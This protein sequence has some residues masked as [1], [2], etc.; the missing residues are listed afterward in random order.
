M[1]IVLFT[2]VRSGCWEE[3][4]VIALSPRTHITHSAHTG[5]EQQPVVRV[6]GVRPAHT[7]ALFVRQ[8]FQA[9]HVSQQPR[10]DERENF[11]TVRRRYS[12]P[13]LPFGSYSWFFHHASRMPRVKFK[14]RA[15]E[16]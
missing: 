13:I 8:H 9:T 11:L 2:R 1:K 6:D 15:A 14:P 12:L 3:V 10:V 16:G 4:S 5:R 7:A